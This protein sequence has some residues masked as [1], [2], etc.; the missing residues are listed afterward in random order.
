MSARFWENM[1]PQYQPTRKYANAKLTSYPD[2]DS[3]VIIVT[4]GGKQ[5][6][7]GGTY[8]RVHGSEVA[9]WPDAASIMAGLM[10]GG[11]PE[12]DLESTPNGAQGYFYEKCMEALDGDSDWTFHFFPWYEFP[13]YRLELVEPDEITPT[14]YELELQRLYHLSLEQIKWRRVNENNLK[15]LF[16][17]EYPED[18]HSCFLLS[19]FGYFGSIDSCFSVPENQEPLEDHIY[20]AG[21]DFGQANDFTVLS[22]AD[23]TTKRQ[24]ALLR[25][26]K[27]PW[28]EIRS[29]VANELMRWKVKNIKVESNNMGS[30][31]IEALRAELRALK[32]ET[33]IQDFET[34]NASK[35]GIMSNLYEH[36]HQNEFHLLSN[37]VLKKEFATF[38]ATQLPSGQWRLAAQGNA[39]DDCVMATAFNLDAMLNDRRYGGIHL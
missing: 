12:I 35:Q 15:Q 38:V 20:S 33:R 6:G 29:R 3:E 10:Q 27:L 13:D 34:N 4:A 22:I 5:G 23:N 9:F 1:L 11:N 19:G 21:L 28:K 2:Y 24:V 30:T 18:P 31:N 25:I 39:H 17:Q 37:P 36:L 8:S 7:R 14:D 32:C 26:N 16:L